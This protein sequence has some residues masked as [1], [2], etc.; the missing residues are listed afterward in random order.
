M[1]LKEMNEVIIEFVK[2]YPFFVD[3]IVLFRTDSEINIDEFLS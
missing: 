3:P 2:K 1:N